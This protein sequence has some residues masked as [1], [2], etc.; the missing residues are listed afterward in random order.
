MDLLHQEAKLGRTKMELTWLLGPN[1]LELP[2][3]V[4]SRRQL[5][6]QLGLRWLEH[7]HEARFGWPGLPHPA[8]A[9]DSFHGNSGLRELWLRTFPG[10]LLWM[11][12]SWKTQNIISTTLSWT[13]SFSGHSKVHR[14][15]SKAHIL[16]AG[17]PK[18]LCTCFEMT[19]ILQQ[20]V[21]SKQGHH[22][23]HPAATTT[24]IWM[25]AFPVCC[26][27][28]DFLKNST[29]LVWVKI[30]WLEIQTDVSN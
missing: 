24:S 30:L 11:S 1:L 17:A 15:G 14:K 26:S 9:S 25:H 7:R 23:A 5:G 12:W 8:A 20:K 22:S 27:V 28:A 19:I 2:I 21:G 10:H 29:G 13:F 4:G 6:S 3:A 18:N 16:I